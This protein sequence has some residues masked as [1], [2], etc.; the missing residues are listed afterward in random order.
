MMRPMD[1]AEAAGFIHDQGVALI[2]ISREI[3]SGDPI[4]RGRAIRDYLYAAVQLGRLAA[5][6]GEGFGPDSDEVSKN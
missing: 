6:V 5:A 4:R 3:R 2:L 1:D